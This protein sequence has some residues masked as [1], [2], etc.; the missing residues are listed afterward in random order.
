MFF[1]FGFFDVRRFCDDAEEASLKM[2]SR[3]TKAIEASQRIKMAVRNV[4]VFRAPAPAHQRL[5][6][7]RSGWYRCVHDMHGPNGLNNSR[8]ASPIS[9]T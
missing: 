5:P 8:S 9:P 3:P 2:P 7:G 1:A 4:H 6:Q